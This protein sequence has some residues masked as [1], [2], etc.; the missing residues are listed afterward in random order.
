MGFFSGASDCSV[1]Q[2]LNFYVFF[3]SNLCV[4]CI[5][6]VNLCKE[7]KLNHIQ[8]FKNYST[9][10]DTGTTTKN[11]HGVLILTLYPTNPSKIANTVNV[12]CHITML[13][14]LPA[15]MWSDISLY[16]T[17]KWF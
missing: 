13:N 9:S 12:Y 11:G 6:K 17:N 2:G 1:R 14:R 15:V 7:L 3:V 5:V 8:F 16:T 10:H 4:K